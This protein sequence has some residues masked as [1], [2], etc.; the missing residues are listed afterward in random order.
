MQNPRLGWAT[1]VKVVDV[2]DGD[3]IKI[4]IEKEIN[5][6]ITDDE[7]TF[8]TPETRRPA[9]D[10]ERDKGK[11]ATDYLSKLIFAG[12]NDKVVLFIPTD[13]SN[14]ISDIFSIGSRLVGHIFINGVDVTKLM[15]E[16]GYNKSHI[17]EKEEE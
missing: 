16:A 1:V 14:K 12:G 17:I 13:G 7:G 10:E 3:T 9:D 6:R 4:K 15:T 8:N 2:I 11:E 5:V